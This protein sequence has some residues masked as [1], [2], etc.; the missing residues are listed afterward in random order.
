MSAICL[1]LDFQRKL[2]IQPVVLILFGHELD[3]STSMAKQARVITIKGNKY[4]VYISPSTGQKVFKSCPIR[5][6]NNSLC[7][8]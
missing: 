2:K 3:A 6:P 5:N 7:D 8:S 4:Q 1:H